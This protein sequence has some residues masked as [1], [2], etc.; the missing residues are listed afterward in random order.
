MEVFVAKQPIFNKDEEIVGYELLYRNDFTNISP[1]ING[2]KATADVII[3]SYLNI[4]IDRISEGKPCYINF[5][6]NLLARKMPTYFN[7]QD[8]VIEIMDTVVPDEG[9]VTTCKELKQSG[10]TIALDQYMYDSQNNYSVDLLKYVDIVKVDFLGLSEEQRDSL[11]VVLKQFPIKLAAKKIETQFAYEQAKA[12]G[13]DLF[14]GYY[15]AEPDIISAYEIPMVFTSFFEEIQQMSL[16]ELDNLSIDE[17]TEKI[18][19]DLSLS[20]KLLKLVNSSHTGETNKISSIREAISLLGMIEIKKWIHVLSERKIFGERKQISNKKVELTLTRAKLCEEIARQMGV[21]IYARNFFMTG[22]IS[23]I[24][25]IASRSME[26]ILA[27][28]PLMDEIHDAL[29]GKEN[30]LREVLDLVTAVENAQ[31]SSINEKC[32]DLNI[33]ERD[34]FRC[35]AESL[36][37]T[38]EMIQLE[39]NALYEDDTL[40]KTYLVT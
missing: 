32:K 12:K 16:E 28:L 10:Y 15:L 34:L 27:D 7:R 2:D 26:E 3:N 30:K 18:E 23:K 14:Q 20:I 25:I 1:L 4:G 9:L 40:E 17:L 37:W 29:M 11:E 8:I 19:K 6:E 39:K 21:P 33:N 5:T 36:N 38:T 24:D 22:L 35:Y 13:Y 31:W